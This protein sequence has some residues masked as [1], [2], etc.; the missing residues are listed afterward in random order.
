MRV[1]DRD[2]SRECFRELDDGSVPV[3]EHGGVRAEVE[4]PADRVVELRNAMTER[5][6]PE[7]GDR[8]EI[9]ATVDVDELVAFGVIDDDRTGVGVGRHLREAVPHDRGVALDPRVVRHAVTN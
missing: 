1:L 9:A 7:R 5:G 4:L 3:P 2:D 8:V 6:H